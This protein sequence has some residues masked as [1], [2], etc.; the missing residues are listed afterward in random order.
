MSSKQKMKIHYNKEYFKRRKGALTESIFCIPFENKENFNEED[1]ENDRF[2]RVM[3]EGKDHLELTNL[4]DCDYVVIPYKWDGRTSQ[5]MNIITEANKNGKKVI[6]L[7]ND[8]FAPL[9]KI[10]PEEGYMFTTTLEK[11]SRKINEFSFPAFCG[12][13]FHDFGGNYIADKFSQKSIGFCGAITH[14]VRADALNKIH[15]I[16]NFEKNFIIRKGFWAPEVT[17]NVAR[18]QYFDNMKDN[19][20]IVC[21]RGAGNFSYRLY[22]T[23][24]MGR[25][26]IIIDSKQSFPF[27]NILNYNNFSII[28]PHDKVTDS[29]LIINEWLS[30]K[31][32]Q[33]LI[34]IQ[35][36]NRDIW[37]NYMSP[38]GWIKSFGKELN[39]VKNNGVRQQLTKI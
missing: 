24:M 8:D 35:H 28:I 23:M 30:N 26:P 27:E 33:D 7:H 16:K 6:V 12:D 14:Q 17:R 10:L 20:F 4:E 25:I 38:L 5:N 13:F 3:R 39:D 34:D 2:G 18:Q 9:Q 29:E 37:L 31:T 32:T 36:K 19:C 11:T 15:S 22:E 1:F 21:M